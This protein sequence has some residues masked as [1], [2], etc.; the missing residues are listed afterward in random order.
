[1][2]KEM[3]ITFVY[4][5]QLVKS[6][7]DDPASAILYFHPG[8]VSD[9]QRTALCG[10]IMG[11]S[12]FLKSVFT[13]PKIISLQSGKFAIREYGKYILAVGT[14]RN[15]ADWVLEYRADTLSSLI[16]FFH[17]DLEVMGELY[18]NTETLSAKLYHMFETYLKILTYS[19]NLFSN[20]PKINLP[21]SASNV[22]LEAI[23]ILQCCQEVDFVLG[24]TMLYHN[25]VVATQLSQNLTKRLVLTDPYRIKSP[26]EIFEVDYQLPLGVQ[27]LQVYIEGADYQDLL[28]E[29]TR[30][31][32]VHQYLN[33]KTYTKKTQPMKEPVLSAMKRDQ[34]LIFTTVPEEDPDANSPINFENNIINS[35]PPSRPK[36]LNLRNKTTDAKIEE[37]PKME[38]STTTPFHGKTSICS[39][40]MTDLNKVVHQNVMS[41]CV[42]PENGE[43]SGFESDQKTDSLNS[44]LSA[45][46]ETTEKS[47]G[48][49]LTNKTPYFTVNQIKPSS[50][51]MNVCEKPPQTP[52]K[53]PKVYKTIAD[54]T[55]PVFK[56][57]GSLVSESFYEQY[58]NKHVDMLNTEASKQQDDCKA[59]DWKSIEDFDI[60]APKKNEFEMVPLATK[61]AE[62]KPKEARKSLSLPLKSL[63]LDSNDNVFSP[64]SRVKHCG[65]VQLT[66]L[67][68]KL[69]L[70]AMEEKS[71]GFCSRETTPSEYK[72]YRFTPTHPN[73]TFVNP[74][75]GKSNKGESKFRTR[76]H[77]KLKK[78]VL[79]VCGQ[80]DMVV[81]LLLEEDG[82]ENP[83][84]IKKLW[85]MCVEYLGK[86]EK[87]L[88]QCLEMCPSNNNGQN[89]EPYSYLTMEQHWDTVQRGGPWGATEL[90]ALTHLHRDFANSKN[91]TEILL[92]DD[93]S[94]IY[95]HHSGK[96]EVYYLQAASSNAGLPTP[97]DPMGVVPLKAKRRLERDHGV[98][99]L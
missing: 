20:I 38:A 91:L 78:G 34:S 18:K 21:K 15:I 48:T 56:S 60:I 14:D 24:G 97:A 8:W 96:T 57:D 86:L 36:F 9:Q 39:T 35:A 52:E 88:R 67:M 41:I 1:M 31:R 30:C 59:D 49:K 50:S 32:T 95:G 82:C 71:S 44:V 89:G 7:E 93:D 28:E 5:T 16:T 94:I 75:S 77:E 55:F 66:P 69:S 85:E 80:Q 26:A 65:G 72:D 3:M 42:N 74:K 51:L 13:C 29:A 11:V 87:Q 22:F 6:E 12:H 98:I 83:E 45:V 73:Y 47:I 54:P 27:L 17:N 76:I 68:S 53:K 23:Q 92:R 25:K 10:Q 70:L 62:A 43:N 58:L 61:V 84:M 81:G 33:K 40:P 79:F 64:V 90:G 63:S 4:D 2:A 37:K 19:S 46:S 99:L